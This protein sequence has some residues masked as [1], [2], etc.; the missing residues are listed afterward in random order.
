METGLNRLK[1]HVFTEI[2]DIAGR[3]FVL[4]RYSPAVVIGNRGFTDDEKVNGIILVFNPRMKFIWDEEGLSATLVFGSSPQK[5]FVPAGEIIAIYS[6][7]LGAQFMASP[8]SSD[9][10]EEDEKAG[11]TSEVVSSDEEHKVIKVDFS[12]KAKKQS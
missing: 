1:K 9:D 4:V 10:E 12:K 11:E 5:C 8:E 3:V 6:P 7:E 2:M